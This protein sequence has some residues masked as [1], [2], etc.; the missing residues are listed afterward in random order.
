MSYAI[1]GLALLALLHF[2][3]ESVLAPSFRMRL[4]F[5][6]RALRHE[7]RRL[8]ATAQPFEREQ[9][10]C[11]LD[12]SLTALT[13]VLHRFD[14]ATLAAVAR[15]IERDP[16]L[17]EQVEQRRRAL[18]TCGVPELLE[19]RQRIL[20][21]ATRALIVNHGAWCLY[22]LPMALGY[23]SIGNLRRLIRAAVSLPET[24]LFRIA[25]SSD[26]RTTLTPLE[27]R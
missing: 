5:E 23:L 25:P 15:E 12:E 24:D 19:A 18:D 26:R 10:L 9:S 16:N 27:H 22:V 4:H 1:F 2:V 7:L 6:L 20:H 8:R 21:V 3:Y 11:Y 14:A 17:R 13:S